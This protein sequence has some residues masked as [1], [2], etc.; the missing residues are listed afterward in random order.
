MR[1][2]LKKSQVAIAVAQQIYE[3]YFQESLTLDHSE[4]TIVYM[5]NLLGL[6]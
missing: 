1:E 4:L 3:P 5:K 2:N 6:K